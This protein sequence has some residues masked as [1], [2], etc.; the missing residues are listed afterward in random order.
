MRSELIKEIGKSIYNFNEYGI[1]DEELSM[2]LEYSNNQIYINIKRA[3]LDNYSLAI[4]YIY[5][6]SKM[7]SYI[8]TYNIESF[9][10]KYQCFS[11]RSDD[12]KN[13]LMNFAN[14]MKLIISL[15][16]KKQTSKGFLISIIPKIIEGFNVKYSTG[17]G[18]IKKVSDFCLIYQKE[19]HNLPAK[20]PKIINKK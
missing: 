15:K 20:R 10:N 9:I 19:T 7:N 6:K 14:I 17:S 12:E 4:V 16:I 8:P 18:Q 5:I 3:N 1:S 2:I 11:E 13:Y